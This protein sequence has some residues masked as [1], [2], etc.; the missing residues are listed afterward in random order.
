M[1]RIRLQAGAALLLAAALLLTA[2]P[3]T[4][5]PP[6]RPA[7]TAAVAPSFFDALAAW[8]AALWPGSGLGSPVA[9]AWQALGS[10]GEASGEPAPQHGADLDPAGEPTPQPQHGI[11]LD[12]NG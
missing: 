6:A 8:L 12:P 11:D 7:E 5:G 3:A 1:K 2:A 4:A 9:P 10:E